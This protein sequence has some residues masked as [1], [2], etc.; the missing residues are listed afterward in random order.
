MVVIKNLI[1]I[2]CEMNLYKKPM[3]L[4]NSIIILIEQQIPTE[5][6]YIS[7]VWVLV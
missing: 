3:T 6:S 2:I 7:F 1:V 5:E 4:N